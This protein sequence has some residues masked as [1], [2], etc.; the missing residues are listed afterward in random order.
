M[1]ALRQ[2]AEVTWMGLASLPARKGAAAV[3]IT[4]I[5]GVVGVLVALLA[6]RNGF[7]AT[8]GQTGHVDEAIVLRAGANSE[9]ASQILREDALLIARTPGVSRDIQGNPLASPEVVVVANL[10]LRST[11]TDANAQIRGVGPQAFALR[12]GL[13]IIEGRTFRPGRRELLAGRGAARQFKGLAPGNVLMLNQEPWTVAGIFATDDATESEIWADAEVVQ[14][15]YRRNAYQSVR[16]RLTDPQALPRLTAGLAENPQLRVEASTTRD[17]Y[18]TQSLRLRRLV[19]FLATTVASIM[20]VGAIFGALNTM[21]AA[22]AA[23]TRE[24]AILRALGFGAAPVVCSVLVEGLVLA[25]AGGLLGAGVA[26]MIFDQYTVSTLGAN[27]SQV[28]FAFRVTGPLV[29]DALALA[30]AI[31]FLG[32]LW[33]AL[34]AAR[35]PIPQGLRTR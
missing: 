33:P 8:L 25:L 10:P 2:I 22:V 29:F 17:Y 21:H 14:S 20:A 4:G 31:G 26:W 30:L 35:M 7:E 15:T 3:V 6:M 13:Q 19:N 1:S 24:I 11:G 18:A 23:R 27:F 28:V 34:A 16:V 9:L 5:A 32:A 12:R